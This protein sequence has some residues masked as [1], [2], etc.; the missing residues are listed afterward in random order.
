MR[1]VLLFSLLLFVSYSLTGQTGVQLVT[2]AAAQ[3]TEDINESFTQTNPTEYASVTEYSTDW[4]TLIEDT[5]SINEANIKTVSFNNE[6][7]YGEGPTITYNETISNASG[8]GIFAATNTS[9]LGSLK[10]AYWAYKL[11]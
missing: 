6:W 1:K 9:I 3:A 10:S 8:G 5:S 7:M 11:N 4:E 2:P